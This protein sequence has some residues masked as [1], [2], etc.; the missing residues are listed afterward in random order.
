MATALVDA[1]RASSFVTVT[2]EDPFRVAMTLSFT[3]YGAT[4][5][6]SSL[7]APWRL[8]LQGAL[9]L[10]AERTLTLRPQQGLGGAFDAIGEIALDDKE[11]D[12]AWV[13]RGNDPGLVLQMLPELR[14]LAALAPSILV[15]AASIEVFYEELD[16]EKAKRAVEGALALWHRVVFF[17]LG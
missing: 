1:V 7:E 6:W 14:A 9:P 16:A 8:K 3:E 13:V 10:A 5:A 2:E 12:A 17:R 11:V 4:L 15:T